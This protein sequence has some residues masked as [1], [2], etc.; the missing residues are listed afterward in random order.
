MTLKISCACV[1]I[2]LWSLAPAVSFAQTAQQH[3]APGAPRSRAEGVVRQ[4]GLTLPPPPP[5]PSGAPV[6]TG[7]VT[8]PPSKPPAKK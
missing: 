3:N 5:A 4:H 1:S 2:A 7:T 8:S 6:S